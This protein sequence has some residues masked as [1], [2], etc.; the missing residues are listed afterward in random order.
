MA[1]IFVDSSN[2]GVGASGAANSFEPHNTPTCPPLFYP[3]TCGSR[4][5]SD[6]L[7]AILSEIGQAIDNAGL[8]I[9]CGRTD[10]LNRAI[11]THALTRGWCGES[12]AAAE[13]QKGAALV[14]GEYYLNTSAGAVYVIDAANTEWVLP[15]QPSSFLCCGTGDI[16][17]N[18]GGTWSLLNAGETS[19]GPILATDVTVD[20][21]PGP[22]DAGDLQTALC[23]LSSAVMTPTPLY[24]TPWFSLNTRSYSAA[25][26]LSFTPRHIEPIIKCVSANAGYS[27]GTILNFTMLHHANGYACAIGADATNVFFNNEGGSPSTAPPGGGTYAT[28]DKT[29]WQMKLIVWG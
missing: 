11:M 1:G 24:E 18:C 26:G 4:V 28:I 12:R 14:P 6:W 22:V 27:A 23:A 13:A 7:N 20:D 3:N 10:N 9:K 16:W 15:N 8:T 25:H 21:C 19:S 17:A 2:G 29:K 5:T